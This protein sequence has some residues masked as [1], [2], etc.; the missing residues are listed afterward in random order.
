MSNVSIN[1]SRNMSCASD[2]LAGY[3]F[4]CGRCGNCEHKVPQRCHRCGAEVSTP[5]PRFEE[6]LEQRQNVMKA[7]FL[8]EGNLRMLLRKSRTVT[9]AERREIEEML[10]QNTAAQTAL[11]SGSVM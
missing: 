7:L 8:E 10:R 5:S 6:A 1:M 11:E 9:D 2:R 3:Y 4:V